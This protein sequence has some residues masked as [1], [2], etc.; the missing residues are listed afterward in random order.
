MSLP[1]RSASACALLFQQA[2]VQ[3]HHYT[4]MSVPCN[5]IESISDHTPDPL[6]KDGFRPGAPANIGETTSL[7][8]DVGLENGEAS[9]LTPSSSTDAAP[10]VANYSF[11]MGNHLSKKQRDKV[12]N[13]LLQYED[14]F[15][16]SI[17]DL[18]KCKTMQ[19]S[20]N[21]SDETPIYQRRHR[22]SKHE[23]EL[24]DERCKE[25]HDSGLI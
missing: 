17:K 12:L 10:C 4:R 7:N 19:F 16:F 22:L 6:Y 18:G 23:W 5:L 3:P 20:I 24:V 8:Q 1:I 11:I 25:L 15:A 14:V 2:A 13:L 21:L 9:S